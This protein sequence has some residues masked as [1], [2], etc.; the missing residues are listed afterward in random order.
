MWVDIPDWD[1]TAERVLTGVFGFHPFAVRDCAHRNHVPKVHVYGDHVFVV[2]HAPQAGSAGH[3]H[4]IEVG[5]DRSRTCWI[6]SSGW[7]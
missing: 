2:L 3:V 1:T 6:S 7:R 4:Y 5:T